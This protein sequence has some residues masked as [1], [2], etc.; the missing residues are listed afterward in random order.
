MSPQCRQYPY[1]LD[2]EESSCV[3]GRIDTSW[4]CLLEGTSLTEQ[5]VP[6]IPMIFFEE[7]ANGDFGSDSLHSKYLGRMAFIH[8]L[9]SSNS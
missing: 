3:E 5:N 2:T 1:I 8:C 7:E 9:H 4:K 6:G